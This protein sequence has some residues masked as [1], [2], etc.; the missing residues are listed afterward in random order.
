MK[1]DALEL[2][3]LVL[4]IVGHIVATV[5]WA[6]TITEKL[7]SIGASLLIIANNDSENGKMHSL[8]W[9]R[10]DELGNR[11]TVIET[12]CTEHHKAG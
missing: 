5:W 2:V 8:L 10:Q 7:K 1:G 11:I 4:V 6:A 9:K 12:K 3:A